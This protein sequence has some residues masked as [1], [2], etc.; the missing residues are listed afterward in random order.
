MESLFHLS[1]PWWEFVVRGL[2]IYLLLIIGLRFSGKTRIGQFSTVDFVLLILISNAVQNA[3]NGGDNSLLGGI[4][5]AITLMSFNLFTDYLGARNPR[6][7]RLYE[8]APEIL[9]YNGKLNERVLKKENIAP[10]EL[11]AILRQNEVTRI[12]DV[13]LAVVEVTGDVSVIKK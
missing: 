4:I 7:F 1:L 3:M 12:E 5:L 10:D 8:G 13:K 9:I 2:A 6:F 11:K